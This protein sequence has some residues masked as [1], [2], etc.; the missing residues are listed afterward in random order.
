MPHRCRYFVKIR[1]DDYVCKKKPI[2]K[3]DRQCRVATLMKIITT[4]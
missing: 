2:A 1:E 4:L 3:K